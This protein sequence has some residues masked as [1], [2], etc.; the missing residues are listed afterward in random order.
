MLLLLLLLLLF[1][2]FIESESEIASHTD[3]RESAVCY[4]RHPG[5]WHVPPSIP[6]NNKTLY[7]KRD[8]ELTLAK[9]KSVNFA[10][11]DVQPCQG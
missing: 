5:L 2:V 10:L 7:R 8:P 11:L 9:L 3:F 6:A 4:S 1:H